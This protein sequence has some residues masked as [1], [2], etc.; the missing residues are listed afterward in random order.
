MS[1]SFELKPVQN[2]LM[3]S[4]VSSVEEIAWSAPTDDLPLALEDGRVSL[5]EWKETCAEIEGA[6]EWY[7]QETTGPWNQFVIHYSPMTIVLVPLHIHKKRTVR[8][9]WDQKMTNIARQQAQYFEKHRIQVTPV[10]EM[11]GRH[12]HLHQEC[13]GLKFDVL[14]PVAE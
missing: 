6:Y 8:N 3:G 2:A 7:L 1:V 14:P 12:K 13:V 4:G 10:K 9:E 11:S 5:S